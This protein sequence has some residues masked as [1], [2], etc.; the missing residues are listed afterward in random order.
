MSSGSSL[1]CHQ[2]TRKRNVTGTMTLCN[3]A[4][5]S[6]VSFGAIHIN[7]L[8]MYHI[9]EPSEGEGFVLIKTEIISK[10][11]TNLSRKAR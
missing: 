11:Q 8:R 10:I 5:S 6:I 7:Y 4:I 9:E 3:T 2:S 1:R